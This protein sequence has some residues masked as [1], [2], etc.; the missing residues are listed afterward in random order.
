M[1]HRLRLTGKANGLGTGKK[2]DYK[3]ES[4]EVR[5]RSTRMG[6]W[7]DGGFGTVCQPE[8]T[9]TEETLNKQWTG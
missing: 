2:Q 1:N 6:W 8:S 7:E 4:R 9:V 5:K 3:V